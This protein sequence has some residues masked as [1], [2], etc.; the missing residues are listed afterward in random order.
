M[1]S[2]LSPKCFREGVGGDKPKH[3]SERLL[4]A[5][6][7]VLLLSVEPEVRCCARKTSQTSG[8]LRTDSSRAGQNPVEGLTRDAQLAGRLA[9]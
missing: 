2:N 4:G 5:P 8:H 3:A 1:M 6:E 9:D 7:I